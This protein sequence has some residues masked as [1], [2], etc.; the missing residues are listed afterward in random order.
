[1]DPTGYAI[2]SWVGT[3]AV[4]VLAVAC[5]VGLLFMLFNDKDHWR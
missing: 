4:G 1:M 3:S 5:V 2:P